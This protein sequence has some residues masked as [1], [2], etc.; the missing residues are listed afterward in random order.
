MRGLVRQKK[1]DDNGTVTLGSIA[2]VE[3][4]TTED[5]KNL[6]QDGFHEKTGTPT[7][8]GIRE[9]EPQVDNDWMNWMTDHAE[10][11]GAEDDVT[12]AVLNPKEVAKARRTEIEF[13]RRKRVYRKMKRSEIPRGAVVIR[14]RW[15]D[16]N[17]GDEQNPDY[18]SRLVAMQFRDGK[19]AAEWFAATPPTEA[20]RIIIST[21]A[22]EVDKNGKRYELMANDVRRA[23]FYAQAREE[24]YVEL[25]DEDKSQEDIDEDRVGVLRLAM[26]GTRSA[27]AAW[28]ER[29]TEVLVKNGYE[30]GRANPC[31]FY[32]KSRNLRTLIHGD[33]FFSSGPREELQW[34]D[35]KLKDNFEL[36]TNRISMEPGEEREMK[37]LNQI[38][39]MTKD[40]IEYEADP[41]HGELVV[42]MLGLEDAN[43]VVTPGENM[44][45]R[46]SEP[47][48]TGETTM[49]RAICARCNYLA[50]DRV[51]LAYAAKE[52][53]R[54]MSAPT[55]RDWDRLK[56]IGRYLKTR[57]RLVQRF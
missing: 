47:L 40:G 1:L 49:Y 42:K 13:F 28:Q 53:C 15:V 52:C 12:G 45:E 24:V 32:N 9:K 43:G 25:P 14:V 27:A 26:Y 50:M 18:R 7:M 54:R 46:E 8:H 10:E 41:R 37:M 16:I 23:Y 39:R 3:K 38:V 29:V 22:M 57:P 55:H 44:E 4:M 21:A 2:R 20:M 51:D 35:R 33:D 48:G 56:R 17:K 31:V 36:K 11:Y 19:G 34:L 6:E 30:K 5:L